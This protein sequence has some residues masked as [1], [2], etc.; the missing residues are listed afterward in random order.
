[1]SLYCIHVEA[2]QFE[3]LTN[4]IEKSKI[5]VIYYILNIFAIHLP[6]KKAIKKL[7]HT[8]ICDYQSIKSY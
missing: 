7:N 2:K 3:R 8:F 5:L 1:M 6:G 4:S